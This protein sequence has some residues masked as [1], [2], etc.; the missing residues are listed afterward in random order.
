MRFRPTRVK[1]LDSHKHP[2]EPTWFEIE[3]GGLDVEL[4]VEHWN[5]AY[6]DPSFFPSEYYKVEASNRKI[7]L[8]KYSTLFKSWWVK[9]FR[10][11]V[12]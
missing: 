8:L 11:E 1:T 10:E 3:G 7:Y 12:Q 4:V 2:G 5:E 9:E 6:V